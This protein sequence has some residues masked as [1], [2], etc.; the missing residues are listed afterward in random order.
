MDVMEAIRLTQLKIDALADDL[1]QLKQALNAVL[2]RNVSSGPPP[3]SDR[4][5]PDALPLNG[6]EVLV[7]LPSDAPEDQ[8]QHTSTPYDHSDSYEPEH[9]R[10]A[11]RSILIIG[12][13]NVRRLQ[14]G[15]RHSDVT[16]H[17]VPG[18][19]TDH[20][21]CDLSRMV[22]KSSA[23]DVVIHVGTNDLTRVGSEV[24]AKNILGL[25]QQAKGHQRVRRVYICSV[26][27]R[28]D[29]GSFI[30]SRS[31]SVNNRLHSLC[32]KTDE[33]SFIDL[34]HQTNVHLMVSRGT[35]CII[36]RSGLFRQCVLSWERLEIF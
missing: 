33:V 6:P 24:V 34:R 10:A 36:A 14:T 35:L 2:T 28:T 18:A 22:E 17:S 3:N 30:F 12:D 11:K 4:S 5:P 19:T 13:S 27:P 29:R 23:T 31:E 16:F 32:L 21:A 26:T 15:S 20:I 8:R 1:H 25:A 9:Q 7:Q